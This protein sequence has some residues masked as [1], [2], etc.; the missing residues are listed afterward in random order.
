M[1]V[2]FHA[3]LNSPV[4]IYSILKYMTSEKICKHFSGLVSYMSKKWQKNQKRSK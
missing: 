1:F 2:L 4:W 3:L